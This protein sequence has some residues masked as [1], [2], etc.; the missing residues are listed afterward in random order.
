MTLKQTLIT[1]GGLIGSLAL[2]G[3]LIK[4]SMRLAPLVLI[5]ALGVCVYMWVTAGSN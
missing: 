4:I 1:I 5:I 2:L 3:L